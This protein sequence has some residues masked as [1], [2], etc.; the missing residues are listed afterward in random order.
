MLWTFHNIMEHE[1]GNIEVKS[2][3]YKLSLQLVKFFFINNNGF[4]CPIRSMGL[5]W[6]LFAPHPLRLIGYKTHTIRARWLANVY[7]TRRCFP[8]YFL[9]SN[10]YLIHYQSEE[11][12]LSHW[13]IMWVL[14]ITFNTESIMSN[15]F[16]ACNPISFK[17]LSLWYPF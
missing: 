12:P 8:H 7:Y 9:P 13:M 5:K 10:R 2:G 11:S 14:P 16:W 6:A 4:I 17:Q 1:D 3:S 15:K